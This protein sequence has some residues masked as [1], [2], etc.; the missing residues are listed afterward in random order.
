MYKRF[1]IKVMLSFVTM[2][3]FDV[4]T[5]CEKA[6]RSNPNEYAI[7]TTCFADPL[8]LFRAVEVQVNPWRFAVFIVWLKHQPCAQEWY[9]EIRSRH[10][11][12]VCEAVINLLLLMG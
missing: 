6:I 12:E 11:Q 10:P 8:E 4:K 3:W 5:L 7:P 2:Q 9:E 1:E